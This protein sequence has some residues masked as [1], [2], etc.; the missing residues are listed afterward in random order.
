[1]LSRTSHTCSILAH[2]GTG[3]LAERYLLTCLLTCTTATTTTYY[4]LPTTTTYYHILLP[5]STCE[6]TLLTLPAEASRCHDRWCYHHHSYHYLLPTTTTYY[7]L[8]VSMYYLLLL[9]NGLYL[10]YLQRQAVVAVGGADEH[11]AP[12]VRFSRV[13]VLHAGSGK[14]FRGRN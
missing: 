7:H 3:L 5:T 4:L 11:R 6:L 2:L 13:N 1:M 8:P 12:A 14:W 10:L 9:A